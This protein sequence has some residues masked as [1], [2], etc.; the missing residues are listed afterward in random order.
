MSSTG[1]RGPLP[2]LKVSEQKAWQG[3]Q[4]R[5]ARSK[6]FTRLIDPFQGRRHHQEQAAAVPS[7]MS[8]AIETAAKWLSSQSA[9]SRPARFL[10]QHPDATPSA[11]LDSL[12]PADR[13]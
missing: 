3:G 5:L 6:A 2:L 10:D 7:D 11:W 1:H 9:S 12:G 13:R 8:W 4:D